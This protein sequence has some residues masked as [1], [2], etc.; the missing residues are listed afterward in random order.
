M[1]FDSNFPAAHENA[2]PPS[3]T[4]ASNSLQK[5]RRIQRGQISLQMLE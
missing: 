5:D 4:G 2:W 3:F 1:P